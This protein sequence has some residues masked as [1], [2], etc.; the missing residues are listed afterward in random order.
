MVNFSIDDNGKICSTFYGENFRDLV[1]IFRKYRITYNPTK[2]CYI[3]DISVYSDIYND[4]KSI[5]EDI[6]VD[7]YTQKCIK[8]FSSQSE[9]KISK[10]RVVFKEDLLKF[11]PLIGK[12]PNEEFQRDDIKKGLSRNRFLFHHDMG[13]GKS[14]ILTALIDHLRYYGKIDK[15]LV[16]SSNIGVQNVKSEIL[17]FSKSLKDEDILLLTSVA[18]TKFENRNIFDSDVYPQK[19][20][21][22]SYDVLK[23]IS[24]YYYD[25][26]KATKKNPHPSTKTDYKKCCIPIKE[27]LGGKDGGIFLDECHNLASPKSRRTEIANMIIPEFEYRYL[28]TG[29][30]SD[31]YEKL[32]EPCWI[33]DPLLVEHKK[34]D[35][36]LSSYNERGTRFSQYAINPDGWDLKK[37]EGLNKKLLEDYSVKRKF[38]DCLDLPPMVMIPIIY[39][40]MSKL[41]RNI[42]E[43]FSN[44]SSAMIFDKTRESGDFSHKMINLFPYL[45]IS[46]DNPSCLKDSKNFEKFTPELQHLIEKYDYNKDN[47]K[48]KIIDD[49]ISEKLEE[50]KKGILWYFHPQT[51]I[52]LEQRYKKYNPVIINRELEKSKRFDMVTYFKEHPEC[53]IMIASINILNTSVTVT[54]AKYQVYVEKTY[55]YMDYEQSLRRIWRKGQED[56]TET[57]SIRFN[58]SIDNL[59]ELNLLCK[60]NIIN[61]LLNKEFIEKGM[62]KK[63]FNLTKDD[64]EQTFLSH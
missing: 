16:M 9:L 21:I 48:L 35:A 36:W 5:G 14:Y 44:Q 47:E 10:T 17:G 40:N 15:C 33:L 53:K 23:S 58:N 1:E 32:Y 55:N 49:I 27:W 42:Y 28:F 7:L 43:M 63:I 24:N 60:G 30:L 18:K 19:V 61:A 12:H 25:R 20:I 29:T 41:Q 50:G 38:T 11:P 62:W 31:K 3:F 57:Y 46:V 56:V 45:Q 8:D 13:L 39:T 22:M 4:V 52:A 2:K 54:E 64:N 6:N 37:I 51:Q 34:Y 26:E 59:Q